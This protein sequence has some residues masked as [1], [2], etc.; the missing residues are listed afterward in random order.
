[1]EQQY[2]NLVFI[3]HD[4]FIYKNY[5][6]Q[7]P[8]DIR[9]KAGERVFVETIKGQSTGVCA[10]NS[11]IVDKFTAEQIIAGTGAYEPIKNVFGWAEKQTDYKCVHFA[12]IDCPF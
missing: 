2:Y 3:K 11:F 9:L 10:S 8:M 6:F 5:L 1:M 7:A 4:N 12:L